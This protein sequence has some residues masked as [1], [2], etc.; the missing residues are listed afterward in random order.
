ME[1][2]SARN[3]ILNRNKSLTLCKQHHR[4]SAVLV[5]YKTETKL[6]TFFM[7][8]QPARGAGLRA[9]IVQTY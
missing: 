3:A 5:V 2:T 7:I 1:I 8:V 4:G 6:S 9:V